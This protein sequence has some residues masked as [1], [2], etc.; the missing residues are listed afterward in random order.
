MCPSH[1]ISCRLRILEH[2]TGGAGAMQNQPTNRARARELLPGPRRAE[3]H[4]RS[5]AEYAEVKSS[6]RPIESSDR[7]VRR[8]ETQDS[9]RITHRPCG[10]GDQATES[11]KLCGC[12]ITPRRTL[13]MK[14]QRA[15][16][17]G[18]VN[19]SQQGTGAGA[20]RT[21]ALR[22]MLDLHHVPTEDWGP[23]CHGREVGAK[24][25]WLS[26]PRVH[27]VAEAP[28]CPRSA[29]RLSCRPIR[30]HQGSEG[31]PHRHL[32]SGFDVGCARNGPDAVPTASPRRKGWSPGRQQVGP[33]WS[34]PRVSR[35]G[36]SK[37]LQCVQ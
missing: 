33:R 31:A 21:A 27:G 24:S 23:R 19:L 36:T 10:D 7:R 25:A 20:A 37:S 17:A 2:P 32:P 6:R 35:C 3:Q 22:P 16:C 28:A 26:S 12:R 18:A 30:G 15:P 1:W 5:S 4:R 29:M 13:I 8:D 11:D 34:Q 9:R 14:R